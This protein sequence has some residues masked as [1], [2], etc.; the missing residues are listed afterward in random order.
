MISKTWASAVFLLLAVFACAAQ[1][2]GPITVAITEPADG[3]AV[4]GTVTISAD[5]SET[6]GT[7]ASVQFQLDG[8][9]FGL[10]VT[11]A[12]YQITWDSTKATNGSSYVITA[13]ALDNLG[14]TATS[15]PVTVTVSN[16]VAPS[17][18][19]FFSGQA[20][21]VSGTTDVDALTSDNTGKVVSAQL[22]VD[23][24][25]VHAPVFQ[26]ANVFSFE[27]DT[28]AVQNGSHVL[29]VVATDDA[30]QSAT[31]SP[32]T[33]TVTNSS[34]PPFTAAL[35]TPADGSTVSGN[36]VNLSVVQSNSSDPLAFVLYVVDGLSLGQG[37][38]QAPFNLAWDSRTVADGSHT[39]QAVVYIDTP[40][41][42]P[43]GTTTAPITV[44]VANNAPP[45]PV[46]PTVSMTA[47]A[48]GASVS[49]SVSLAAAADDA[50]GTVTQVQFLL[51]GSPFGM[52]VTRAPYQI[53]WD[54]TTAP[55]GSHTLAATATN[56]AGQSTTSTAVTVTVS[57][58]AGPQPPTVVITAPAN[59]ATLTG[60]VTVSAD[61]GDVTGRVT[62][63]EFLLDGTPVSADIPIPAYQINLDTTIF[64]NGTHVFTAVATNDTGESTTSAP[65]TVTIN[66]VTLPPPPTV[67]ITFPVNGATVSGRVTVTA[68]AADSSGQVTQ[69]QFFLNGS[70]LGPPVTQ[71]PYSIAWKTQ[72]VP[73]G[74]VTLA[75][76]AT[77]DSGEKTT[78]APVNV[79]VKNHPPVEC[80]PRDRDCVSRGCALPGEPCRMPMAPEEARRRVEEISP[81]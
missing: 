61:A 18:T 41:N 38:Q 35:A 5:A 58:S 15:A 17:F 31:S 50:N 7:I 81:P 59:G 47:P 34:P 11:A 71:A 42:G 25:P 26:V 74:T 39:I 3:A 52:A 9:P 6:G 73:N 76:V 20:S 21:Q 53:T 63:V 1:A 10:P 57:N 29:T 14:Q 27:W 12:P 55:N 22:S 43:E 13:V 45:T 75:A 37:I 78:S 69:V 23:G 56:D 4:S 65:V 44:T 60:V 19:V 54:S 49:G 66:N 70:P 51:D 77:N 33:V 16:T 28:T 48:D 64:P 30:G 80:M 40:S 2:A 67:A 8:S 68:S 62:S 24:T 72:H 36:A 46:P 32:F 79:T